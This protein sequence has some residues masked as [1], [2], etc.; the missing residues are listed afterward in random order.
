MPPEEIIDATG[1]PLTHDDHHASHEHVHSASCSHNH[2][3]LDPFVRS[4]KKT[5]R[6]DTCVCGSNIKYK[7]C[8]GKPQ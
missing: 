3:R 2:H 1:Q 7:K 8:C 5:G 4:E 6:N